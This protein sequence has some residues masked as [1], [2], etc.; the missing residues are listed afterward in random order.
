MSRFTRKGIPDEW[1]LLAMNQASYIHC[2][3]ETARE[4]VWEAV[5]RLRVT[6]AKQKKRLLHFCCQPT[7]IFLD[8]IHILQYLVFLASETQEKAQEAFAPDLISERDMIIR[9][10]AFIVRKALRRNSMYGVTGVCRFIWSYPLRMVREIHSA[11]L[12]P[13]RYKTDDDFR[14]NK[15]NFADMIFTRFS[16]NLRVEDSRKGQEKH[17]KLRSNQSDWILRLVK[18][19]L[20][21]YTP[22]HTNCL[23]PGFNPYEQAEAAAPNQNEHK[24]EIGRLHTLIDPS[25][26][27]KVTDAL[28][29]DV[30][31]TKLA[32]PHFFNVKPDDDDHTGGC[33]SQEGGDNDDSGDDNGDPSLRDQNLAAL[34]N[35]LAEQSEKLDKFVPEGVLTIKANNKEVACL[36]LNVTNRAQFIVDD[37]ETEVIEI[38]AQPEPLTLAVH[39]LDD[40]MWKSGAKSSYVV[41]PNAGTKLTFL[42]KRVEDADTGQP[43][44]LVTV[45]CRELVLRRSLFSLWRGLKNCFSS[46][47]KT[48]ESIIRFLSPPKLVLSAAIILIAIA[49]LFGFGLSIGHHSSLPADAADVGAPHSTVGSRPIED[50]DNDPTSIASSDSI[51]NSNRNKSKGSSKAQ[52]RKDTNE[53]T[54][55]P[56]GGGP[57]ARCI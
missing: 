15:C 5:G 33:G 16:K 53:N 17:F 54:A 55:L 49:S 28:G 4:V 7:R 43:Q 13:D 20:E 14:R 10:L 39:L 3:S 52:N 27:R 34:R 57:L 23:P 47:K 25:C 44:L 22:W 19:S 37:R 32:I 48:I 30:P 18:R 1:M 41:R 9:Y 45:T 21:C 31:D 46:C 36:E 51:D 12:D 11:L 2:Q 50:E 56:E 42:L 40:E 29:F 38:I 8:D 6:S 26:L 35:M 24:A